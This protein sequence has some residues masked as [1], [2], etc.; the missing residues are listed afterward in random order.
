[1]NENAGDVTRLLN[2]WARGDTDAPDRIFTSLYDELRRIASH[3]LL[4]QP[5]ELAL[6]PTL[7]VHEAY[8]RLVDE[9]RLE[10]EGRV[11]FLSI[12]ARVIRR[13]LVDQARRARAQKRGGGWERTYLEGVPALVSASRVELLALDELLDELRTLDERQSRVVELRFFGG[14]G[15]GETAAVL[16]VSP[17]TI[18]EDWRVARAWLRKRLEPRD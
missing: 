18:E 14:L 5:Q 16:D 2:E 11:H 10:C 7:L 15:V 13:V 6:Q 17:R 1:M 9:Q 12:A 3:H 8:I 4:G